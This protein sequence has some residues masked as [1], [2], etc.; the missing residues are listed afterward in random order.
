MQLASFLRPSVMSTYGC[1]SYRH[2]LIEGRSLYSHAQLFLPAGLVMLSRS[3]WAGLFFI[4]NFQLWGQVLNCCH[5][6]W[7]SQMPDSVNDSV[8]PV[9]ALLLIFLYCL[10]FKSWAL[11]LWE[12]QLAFYQ[13]QT[14]LL[15]WR[16]TG[17]IFLQF[18]YLIGQ[19]TSCC[20]FYFTI[21]MNVLTFAC[22]A[23]F[24]SVSFKVCIEWNGFIKAKKIYLIVR[25]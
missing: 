19:I 1:L 21:Q 13:C 25:S 23:S 17:I 22:P 8:S 24:P 14:H 4:W 18:F 2:C 11:I 6:T 7:S 5:R 20:I 10:C 15:R 3:C 12:L 9:W 16:I